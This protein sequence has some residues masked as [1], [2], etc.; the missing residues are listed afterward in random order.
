MIGFGGRARSVCE[1]TSE[2]H[3]LEL[4]V[5]DFAEDMTIIDNDEN[6]RK[7]KGLRGFKMKFVPR[8]RKHAY[9]GQR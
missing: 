3:N 4:A 2:R 9:G 6:E 5:N 8:Q 1:V 7:M